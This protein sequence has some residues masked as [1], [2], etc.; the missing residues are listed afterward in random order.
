MDEFV[1]A[2]GHVVV[3]DVLDLRDVETSGGDSGGHQ[4]LVFTLGEVR[5]S[6]LPLPLGPVSVDAGGGHALSREVSGQVVCA[7][8]LLNKILGL[9]KIY[10]RFTMILTPTKIIVFS[11]LSLSISP[12]RESNF[13][14]LSEDSTSW[15]A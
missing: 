14:L 10:R 7:C 4:D 11:I 3:D 1:G 8:L 5:E 15:K 13:S 12:S 9:N 2:V 6:L